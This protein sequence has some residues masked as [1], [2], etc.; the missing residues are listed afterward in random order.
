MCDI[1]RS[2][3]AA[4]E[5]KRHIVMAGASVGEAITKVELGVVAAPLP[6]SS[7]CGDGLVSDLARDRHDVD[8]GL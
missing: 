3:I 7:E 6:K 1:G 4:L 8:S 2:E 5:Q